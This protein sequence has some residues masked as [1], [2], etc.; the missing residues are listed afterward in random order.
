MMKTL[1]WL[2][3]RLLCAYGAFLYSALVFAQE[4]SISRGDGTNRMVARMTQTDSSQKPRVIVTTDGEVDDRSSMIRFLLYAC[5]F[6]VDGIVEVNS[7][8]QK[9]GHSDEKWI[10]AQL[11]AYE[12]VLPIC[13]SIILIILTAQNCEVSCASATRPRRIFG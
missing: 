1:S 13:E 7:K 8:F 12:Q 4:P 9:R 6:D 2:P 11:A 5:D 3:Q 10:D